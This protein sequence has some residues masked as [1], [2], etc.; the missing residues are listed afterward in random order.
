[1]NKTLRIKHKKFTYVN[2]HKN[3]CRDI[4]GFKY[5]ENRFAINLDSLIRFDFETRH[6]ER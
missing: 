6:K 5:A 2:S 3:R 4:Q 1:M